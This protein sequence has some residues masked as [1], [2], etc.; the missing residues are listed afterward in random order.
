VFSCWLMLA[1]PAG[2]S[3]LMRPE[4][5]PP[6]HPLWTLFAIVIVVVGLTNYLPT[7]FWPGAILAAAGQAA[8][9]WRFL[10]WWTTAAERQLSPLVGLG[11]LAA[12][13]VTAV[14]IGRR[15]AVECE[16]LDRLWAD[17]RNQFGVVW[18]LRVAEKVNVALKSAGH[19]IVLSWHGFATGYGGSIA[20]APTEARLAAETT[21]RSVIRR[22]TSVEWIET[23]LDSIDN[24][25]QESRENRAT[26]PVERTS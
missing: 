20:V 12:A 23:R 3:W 8:L 15:S 17:F 6:I 25:T 21:L 5:P 9:N 24:E 2:Q 4:Y 18:G 13:A 10:W 22:F 19:D 7:R 16:P 11:L 1:L 26:R 14:L